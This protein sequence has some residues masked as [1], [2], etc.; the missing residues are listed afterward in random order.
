MDIILKYAPLVNLVLIVAG[1]VIFLMR[2]N[3]VLRRF[4]QELEEL[5]RKLQTIELRLVKQ[6]TVC[7]LR[8]GEDLAKP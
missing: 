4:V 8:H 6:E 7:V 5:A 1:V 3:D 2:L